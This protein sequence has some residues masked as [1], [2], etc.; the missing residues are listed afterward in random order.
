MTEDDENDDL[1]FM[2]GLAA[3]ILLA[4]ASY[5]THSPISTVTRHLHLVDSTGKAFFEAILASKNPRLFR[6]NFRCSK[7]VFLALHRKCAPYIDG[8]YRSS[9]DEMKILGVLLH[10]LGT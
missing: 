7:D 8:K 4:D 1:M 5:Q 2:Q 10:W 3:S 6:D 9:E